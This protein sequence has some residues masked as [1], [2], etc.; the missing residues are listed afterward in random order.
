MILGLLLLLTGLTISAVAIY[1]SV[2]GL[3]AIFAA[4]TVPIYIMGGTLEVAKLVCASWLKANWEKAPAFIKTYMVIAVI[5]LMAI[6]S[7]GIFGFLS[8]AHTYQSI[9]SG[10]ASA[11][12]AIYDEKITTARNNIDAN[13][14]VIKQMDEA[15][16]QVMVR[17]TSETGADKAVA[18]RKSQA[19]ERARLLSEIQAEQKTISKLNEERAPI[20]AQNRKIEAE[21]GPIKYIA[22][23]IYGDNPDNNL[24]EKAV[25]W[26]IIL[27]VVVFDPLAIVMLLAAQMT[28]VWY[29]ENKEK[30][31]ANTHSNNGDVNR[32]SERNN[33]RD[34]KPSTLVES[35][36]VSTYVTDVEDPPTK[37]EPKVKSTEG[38]SPE[39]ES[40]IVSTATVTEL[41]PHHP[42]THPYLNQGFRT[43]EGWDRVKPIVYKEETTE[44]LPTIED[45]QAVNEVAPDPIVDTSNKESTNDSLKKKVHN[46]EARSASGSNEEMIYVQNSEQTE[47][48]LWKRIRNRISDEFKP[49]DY[50]NIVYSQSRFEDIQ[51]DP[52]QEPELDK[53]IKDIKNGTYSFGDYPQEQIKDFANKIYELRKN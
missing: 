16:D 50:L 22:K 8:K 40:D 30:Q 13:R 10:D 26:V 31:N 53:F 3:A 36:D 5:V 35:N 12:L 6:T 51:Y 24:L 17:S 39:K 47:N 46:Q 43:P 44:P 42:D 34:D 20:A 15:V 37:E 41:A 27:I 32:D 18:I 49:K 14:K 23:L 1:Y 25:T 52:N 28:F 2:L 4:A 7:M 38:N 11:Q 19:K 48:S 33:T 21:V 45:I 9:I 29:K